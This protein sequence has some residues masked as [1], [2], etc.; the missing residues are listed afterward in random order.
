MAGRHILLIDIKLSLNQA[1]VVLFLV[2]GRSQDLLII[3]KYLK[4]Y[5]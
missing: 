4:L 1:H 3:E 2:S 5:F